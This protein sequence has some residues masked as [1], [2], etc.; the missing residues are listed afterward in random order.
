LVLSALIELLPPGMS[1]TAEIII[2]QKTIL[3]FLIE[4][5]IA[6]WDSAFFVC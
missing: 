2:R 6:R 5:L 4:P 3:S 1:G